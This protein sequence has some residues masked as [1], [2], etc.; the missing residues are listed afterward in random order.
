MSGF[1]NTVKELK[2]MVNSNQMA[3][4]FKKGYI[5]YC[6]MT[7]NAIEQDIIKAYN[8]EKVKVD[9]RI[10][11][12][13]RAVL[14]DTITMLILDDNNNFRKRFFE[15]YC[16]LVANWNQLACS[17]EI[18][19]MLMSIQRFNDLM[20]ST[21]ALITVVKRLTDKLEKTMSRRPPY[22][23]LSRHYLNVIKGSLK[24]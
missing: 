16:L 2:N 1:E 7:I 23:E 9:N 17:D 18:N 20:S 21:N 10:V 13:V 12:N 14:N 22:Y 8:S 11:D 5:E 3:R 4:N 15:L 24:R 6:R 19:K